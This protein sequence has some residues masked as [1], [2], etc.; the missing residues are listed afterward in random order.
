MNPASLVP[1]RSIRF[2]QPSRPVG[3]LK[4]CSLPV[5]VAWRWLV[6]LWPLS[7]RGVFA[8][9]LLA[10]SWWL[11]RGAHMRMD[12]VMFAITL[13]GMLLM[14]CV[15]LLVA[16]TSL[17][18]RFRREPLGDTPWQIV[19]GTPIRT[20]YHVGWLGWNPLLRIELAWE[21][22][23]DV[24]VELVGDGCRLVEEV[25]PGCRGLGGEVV[26]RITVQDVFGL[27]R[28]RFRR[29]CAQEFSIQPYPGQVREMP[30]L[31]QYLAGDE[32]GHPE[33]SPQGDPIDMRRYAPGDPMRLVLWKVFARTRRLVVR[34]PERAFTRSVRTMSCFIA[35]DGD[36]A[37]AGIVRAVLE[38]G[39]LGPQF[40]FGADGSPTLT[41]TVPEALMQ[42]VRS[43]NHRREGAANLD[44]LLEQAESLG[45]SACVM[46]VPPRP[47]DWL[48][49]VAAAM[50][51]HRG[52]FAVIVGVES[53]NDI[54]RRSVWQRALFS[55]ARTAGCHKS[56][57]VAVSQSLRELGATVQVID[58]T[59]GA[60]VS[61]EG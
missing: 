21:K 32:E 13:G 43:V 3:L 58:R 61:L 48:D 52:P 9:P 38:R 39:L 2:V 15:M 22:P 28:F 17:R 33:G 16:L 23:E 49:R 18:L 44:R 11:L 20:G 40:L 1:S 7:W 8:L 19:A 56:D 10:V 14:G 25:T 57:V 50:G 35:G 34:T 24:S 36:E 46:F 30:A 27:V 26:R 41:K 29:I 55:K 4:K 60:L 45:T 47:G 12:R 53:M 5:L 59:S 54:P 37:A 31:N 51:R 6:P 42:L